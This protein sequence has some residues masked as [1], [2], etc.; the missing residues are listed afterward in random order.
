MTTRYDTHP[1][2]VM[3]PSPAEI[4]ER[5]QAIREGWTDLRWQQEAADEVEWQLP[6]APDPEQHDRKP[7]W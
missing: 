3:P 4:A 5:C 2:A 6:K 7:N 1:D